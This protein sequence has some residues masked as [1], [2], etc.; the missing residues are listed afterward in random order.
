MKVKLY[1]KRLERELGKQIKEKRQY[2]QR[3]HDWTE[4]AFDYNDVAI[5]NDKLATKLF[6]LGLLMGG[7]LCTL[8]ALATVLY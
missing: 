8:L 5:K 4:A 3:M 7:L 2:E 1:A 6:V